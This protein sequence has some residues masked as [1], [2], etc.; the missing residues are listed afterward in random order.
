MDVVLHCIFVFVHRIRIYLSHFHFLIIGFTEK[1]AR[2][3]NYVR[4]HPCFALRS[5]WVVTDFEKYV[6]IVS[7]IQ[8][9]KKKKKKKKEWILK[10]FNSGLI[11]LVQRNNTGVGSWLN[12]FHYKYCIMYMRDKWC[13]E[14]AIFLAP[15]IYT[16][17]SRWNT[18]C[19]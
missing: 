6:D 2:M 15:I 7:F 4:R 19:F 17:F 8:Q 13:I 11:I 14:H 3:E 5:I 18:K 9:M 10:I 16:Y 12:V 1:K